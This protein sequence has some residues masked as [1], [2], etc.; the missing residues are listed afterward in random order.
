MAG[1]VDGAVGAA[2]DVGLRFHAGEKAGVWFTAPVCGVKVEG[3]RLCIVPVHDGGAGS[4]VAGFM[5]TVI[6]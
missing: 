4:S 1:Q 2:C 3:W 5:K 6:L